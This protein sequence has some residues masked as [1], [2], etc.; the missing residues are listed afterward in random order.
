[1]F[2]TIFKSLMGGSESREHRRRDRRF[3]PACFGLEGM[4]ERRVPSGIGIFPGG[5]PTNGD[6]S[7]APAPVLNTP[8]WP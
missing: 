8:T 7:T 2:T 3:R 6:I 4:E 1:M 5:T